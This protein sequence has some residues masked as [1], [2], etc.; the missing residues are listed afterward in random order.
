M[1]TLE[2]F[3]SIVARRLE[4]DPSALYGST[5]SLKLSDVIAKSPVARNSIDLMEAVAG[6]MAEMDIDDDLELPSMTLDN[7]VAELVV[8][9]EKQLRARQAK[10][11]S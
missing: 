10:A 11:A 7:T 6:A 9:I 2:E 5:P 4:I 3:K 8:E 1:D